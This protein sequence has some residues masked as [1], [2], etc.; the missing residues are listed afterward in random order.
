MTEYLQFLLAQKTNNELVMIQLSLLSLPLA[1]SEI[2]TYFNLPKWLSKVTLCC[3][4][5]HVLSR[6]EVSIYSCWQRFKKLPWYSAIWHG[7]PIR[8]V[9]P[10]Y[11]KSVIACGCSFSCRNCDDSVLIIIKSTCMTGFGPL[12]GS[13]FFIRSQNWG[14]E[15]N[16]A[17]LGGGT[18]VCVC[19]ACLCRPLANK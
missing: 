6:C 17:V 18:C 13:C 5:Q 19:A 1:L 3:S 14:M 8:K 15:G 11:L 4:C 10:T 12:M 16:V 2:Q 7:S 9:L